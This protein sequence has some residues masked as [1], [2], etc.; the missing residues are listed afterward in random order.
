MKGPVLF[1]FDGSDGSAAALT[2]GGAV[3]ARRVALVLTIWET[4][5]TQVVSSG[6]FAFSY[7]PDESELDEREQEAALEAARRG[8]REAEARGWVACPAGQ[9]RRSRVTS[10]PPPHT[11]RSRAG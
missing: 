9:C 7:V 2:R 6:S 11:D 4:V 8:V 1:C 3:L 5:T 10:Q